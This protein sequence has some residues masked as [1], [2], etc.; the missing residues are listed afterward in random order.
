MNRLCCFLTGGHRYADSNLRV[1]E[2]WKTD[3]IVYCNYCVKCGKQFRFRTSI[4]NILPDEMCRNISEALAVYNKSKESEVTTN[5][6][7]N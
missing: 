6:T 5:E 7:D 2:D 1:L 4:T 3:G